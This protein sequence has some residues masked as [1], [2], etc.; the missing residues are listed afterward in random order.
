MDGGTRHYILL[1]AM[2]ASTATAMHYIAPGKHSYH[3]LDYRKN[4][5]ESEESVKSVLHPGTI[6]GND[7]ILCSWGKWLPELYLLGAPKCA[8]SDL[9]LQLVH[10]GIQSSVNISGYSFNDPD[11]LKKDVPYLGEKESQFF[12][13]WL[14]THNGTWDVEEALQDWWYYQAW[15]P[16]YVF[17]GSGMPVQRTLFAEYTPLNLGLVP[18]DSSISG[19]LVTAWGY[20][21]AG[22]Y[23]PRTL[24][25][26]YGELSP[27][28][29][30]IVMLREPLAQLQSSWYHAHH[31]L[32]HAEVNS[33]QLVGDLPLESSF[34]AELARALNL[35]DHGTMQLWLWYSYYGRQVQAYLSIFAASQFV[36]IPMYYF[37]H[38][39]RE[40]VCA[41]LQERLR[42]PISCQEVGPSINTHD[43]PSLEEDL[44]ATSALRARFEAFMQPEIERLIQV[45][46]RAYVQGAHLPAFHRHGLRP[47]RRRD[48]QSWLMEGW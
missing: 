18:P 42:Y 35:A 47:V 41:T 5:T 11:L 14:Y 10:N 17:E 39:A 15:C 6:E 21:L 2:A 46:H 30:F 36:F 28:L 22:I 43:H 8:T 44:P 7:T 16:A 29:S 31:I 9:S 1:F 40:E 25:Y 37:L 38:K 12:Q 20:D 26:F 34:P 4:P 13:G 19:K 48:V 3:N 24:A 45:L 23:L 33:T 32:T 27:K